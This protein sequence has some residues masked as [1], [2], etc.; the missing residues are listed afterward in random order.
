[1]KVSRFVFGLAVILSTA[2]LA[3]CGGGTGVAP[4]VSQ[5]LVNH[6]TEHG[7]AALPQYFVEDLGTLGGAGGAG[8]TAEAISNNGWIIGTSNLAGDT[9]NHSF[10]WRNGVMTDLGTLGGM[11]SNERGVLVSDRIG[12]V[13]GV[14]QTPRVDP[15][16]EYWG[17]FTFYCNNN[18][19]CD[20]YKN[21]V[22]GFARRNG[23]LVKLPTL[24]SNNGE[25]VGLN[26]RGQIVGYAEDRTPDYRCAPPQILDVEA[27]V[28]EPR[29]GDAERPYSA[30]ALPPLA[31]DAVAMAGQINDGGQVVGTSSPTCAELFSTLN[32]HNVLWDHGSVVNMGNLGGVCCNTPVDI[33]S[34]G[35]VVGYSGTAGNKT[36]HAFAWQKGHRMRDLG[37]LRNDKSSFG[38]GIN[39]QGDIVGGSCGGTSFNFCTA[40]IWRNGVMTDLNTRIKR[41]SA[42]LFLYF[43]ND[44]NSEGE[45]AF[46]AFDPR[47]GEF[48]AAIGIPCDAEHARVKGCRNGLEGVDPVLERPRVVLPENLRAQFLR[49]VPLP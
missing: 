13:A 4:G 32:T 24:G 45:I 5:T 33:N 38:F 44:I 46:Y 6:L 49:R 30:H 47:K 31:G 18:G 19:P 17:A 10:V 28:W 25:A 36:F 37:T 40:L 11:N 15:L 16:G 9:V 12:L 21:V 20:G 14:S 2:L 3:S 29:S 39:D 8:A 1:M 27:V 48:R 23:A 42:P 22:R 41:G 26:D 7:P 35:E 43:G 34:G